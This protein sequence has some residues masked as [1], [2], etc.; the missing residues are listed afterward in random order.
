MAAVQS[1]VALLSWCDGDKDNIMEPLKTERPMG[2]REQTL[3]Q[4][5]AEDW[6]LHSQICLSEG[7]DAGEWKRGKEVLSRLVIMSVLTQENKAEPCSH[8]REWSWSLDCQCTQTHREGNTKK[9]STKVLIQGA[10]LQQAT[11]SFSNTNVIV[12]TVRMLWV[13]FYLMKL[14]FYKINRIVFK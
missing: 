10:D 9:V 14:E 1:K 5:N 4:L 2:E 13:I 7:V 8:G 12:T 11:N 3:E 6:L